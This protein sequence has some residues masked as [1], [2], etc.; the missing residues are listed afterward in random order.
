MNHQD[1]ADKSATG[2]KSDQTAAAKSDVAVGPDAKVRV[3]KGEGAT[4]GGPVNPKDLTAEEQ[5]ALF[6]KDLKENDW[7]H[8]PC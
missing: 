7:G 8:Q 4:T 3:A 6:E 1:G 2:L 5:M